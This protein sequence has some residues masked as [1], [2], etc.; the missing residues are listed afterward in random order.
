MGR[1]AAWFFFADMT[2][3]VW[4]SKRGILDK[5][6]HSHSW[7][8]QHAAQPRGPMMSLK[9]NPSP[10]KPEITGQPSKRN[11]PE[12][13]IALAAYY[14]WEKEGHPQGHELDHWLRA[15]HGVR[16]LVDADKSRKPAR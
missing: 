10:P 13:E 5:L 9:K 7:L 8:H 16:R 1:W 14:I 6:S 3:I 12:R 15:E 4:W 2:G 11:G